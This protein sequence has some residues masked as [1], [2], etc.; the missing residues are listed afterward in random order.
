MQGRLAMRLNEAKK[1]IYE[2][3]KPRGYRVSFERLDRHI[4]KGDHFPDRDEPMIQYEEEAWELAAKFAAITKG[5]NVNVYV[6]DDQWRPVPGYEA[7]IE[8]RQ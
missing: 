6:V 7:K 4:L 8:N 1:I 3:I 2:G 5:R